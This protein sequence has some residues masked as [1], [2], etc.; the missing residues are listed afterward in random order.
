MI[1]GMLYIPHLCAF[2]SDWLF[3]DPYYIRKVNFPFHVDWKV[4]GFT[5]LLIFAGDKRQDSMFQNFKLGIHKE[6]AKGEKTS[7]FSPVGR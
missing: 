2:I 6:V 4:E 7:Y 1:S 3:T 5:S